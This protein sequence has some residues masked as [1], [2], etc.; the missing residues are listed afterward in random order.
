[1]GRR[2]WKDRLGRSKL[3]TDTKGSFKSSRERMSSRTL[4]VAV[5]VK[6]ETTGRLGSFPRNSGMVR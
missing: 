1:M 4:G 5:A 2:T 3:V 6:A